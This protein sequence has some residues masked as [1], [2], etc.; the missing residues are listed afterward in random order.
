MEARLRLVF[1]GAWGQK[2]PE[3]INSLP[4][5]TAARCLWIR[6]PAAVLTGA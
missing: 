6:N 5:V 1:E 3:W 2:M 4:A